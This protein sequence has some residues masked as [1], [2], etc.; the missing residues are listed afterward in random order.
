[1]RS[2]ERAA[3][4]A[5]QLRR[6]KYRPLMVEVTPPACY[7]EVVLASVITSGGLIAASRPGSE[8]LDACR[9]FQRMV[10]FRVNVHS[11]WLC[12]PAIEREKWA[13]SQLA[14]KW[15]LL[16]TTLPV[17][18]K[19]RSLSSCSQAT[20]AGRCPAKRGARPV[21]APRQAQPRLSSQEIRAAHKTAENPACQPIPTSP[22]E[23]IY[24][25]SS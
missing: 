22:C 8:N 20:L 6:A 15:W 2:L 1:M 25:T 12:H 14:C 21:S 13:E 18:P 7:G 24:R 11:H 23:E 17:A 3:Q 9:P 16:A 10:V 4:L 19:L 5:G